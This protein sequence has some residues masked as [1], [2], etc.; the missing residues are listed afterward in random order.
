MVPFYNVYLMLKISGCPGYWFIPFHLPFLLL[1]FFL[2]HNIFFSVP[3]IIFLIMDFGIAKNFGKGWGYTLG[4][5]FVPMIFFPML[6]GDDTQYRERFYIGSRSKHIKNKV[7]EAVI[8]V[9]N[10]LFVLNSIVLLGWEIVA[11][12]I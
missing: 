4:L 6:G 9:L 2:P 7:N 10:S 5:F 11:T 3:F 8:K 1:P 12:I